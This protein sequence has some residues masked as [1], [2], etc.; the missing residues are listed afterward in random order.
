MAGLRQAAQNCNFGT[1]LDTALRSQLVCG[2]RDTEIQER[3]CI[4]K[5]TLGQAL[6]RACTMESVA[7]EAQSLHTHGTDPI[8]ED[9][10]GG[11]THQIR[12]TIQ[13]RNAIDVEALDTWQ[14]AAPLRPNTATTATRLAIWLVYAE[15]NNQRR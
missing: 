14:L 2:L 5:L 4:Q 10:E 11:S 7:K 12:M 1:Y 8:P 3:L 6:E 15:A 9:A 13:H